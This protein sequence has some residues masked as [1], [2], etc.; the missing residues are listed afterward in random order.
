RNRPRSC[1]THAEQRRKHKSTF[2]NSLRQDYAQA[3]RNKRKRRKERELAP[4]SP[5]LE[6][7]KLVNFKRIFDRIRAREWE[8]NIKRTPLTYVD[9]PKQ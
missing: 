3:S 7:W 9:T 2:D 1:E 6:Q 8:K 5:E 4:L